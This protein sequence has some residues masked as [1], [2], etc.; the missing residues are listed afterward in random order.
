VPASTELAARI[1]APVLNV[2]G[3]RSGPGFVRGAETVQSWFPH[4]ERC[5][6]PNATHLLMAEQP[7]AMA[8]EIARFFD[9]HA[10]D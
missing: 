10:A 5:T 7:D 8:A 2:V 1:T 6:L 3:E 9:S 4:A